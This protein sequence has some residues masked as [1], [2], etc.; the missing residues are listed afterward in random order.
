MRKRRQ[1]SPR[2][3]VVAS[4]GGLTVVSGCLFVVGALTN[5][6]LQFNYLVQNLFLAWLPLVFAGLLLRSLPVQRWSDWW[7][8]SL[9]LLWLIFLPN[10]F[11]MVSD[12]VH[13]QDVP[14]HNL[15]Y[16]VV[17]FTSFI[18]TAALVGFCSLYLVHTELRKRLSLRSSS[19]LIAAVLL[20]C[21]FAIYLGRDLRWNSWDVLVNPAGIL[22]DV[23]DHLLHPLQHFAMFS[24]TLSFFVLL[25]SL[26]VV[27]WQLG[28]AMHDGADHYR[29]AE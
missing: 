8:L 21:S 27:G 14:R 18:F 29:L 2:E 20:L 26:Y 25:G 17:M 6:S 13:I 28:E 10:S 4:L 24:M 22:F 19:L 16:D 23:S 9:T 7:P 15:L 3:R 12:F 11:Y 5:H 1:L